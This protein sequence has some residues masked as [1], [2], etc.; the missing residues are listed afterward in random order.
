[1]RRHLLV[2]FSAAPLGLLLAAAAA[3]AKPPVT[4]TRVAT[5]SA[6]EVEWHVTLSRTSVPAGSVL[7]TVRNSGKLSHQFIVLRTSLAAAKLPMK[8]SQVD[9]KKAGKVLGQIPRLAP[10]KTMRVMLTLPRGRY[11]LL[12]NLPAHYMSGQFT[13][14]R[15][16]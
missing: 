7:F 3:T 9:L 15:V 16:T 10:G 1:M 13:T 6:V 12:C 4:F 2:S 5:V 11:V 14:F 8:G